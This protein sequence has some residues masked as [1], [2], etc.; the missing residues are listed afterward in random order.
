[1]MVKNLFQNAMLRYGTSKKP[2]ED[3]AC[4]FFIEPDLTIILPFLGIIPPHPI[5]RF[6]QRKNNWGY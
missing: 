1:M 5:S 3:Q 2:K 6:Q 4:Q